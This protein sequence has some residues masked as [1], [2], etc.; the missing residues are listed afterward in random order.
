MANQHQHSDRPDFNS[1]DD[2]DKVLGRAN[3]NPTR[4][5]CPPR[6]VLRALSRRER[7]IEDPAYE[8][9]AKCS[10]CFREFRAMQQGDAAELAATVR[11][12]RIWALAA[13]AVG[14]ALVGTW[15]ILR[16]REPAI[17]PSAQSA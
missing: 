13:A 9:L 3:P 11:S 10:P 14:V 15:S 5:G 16:R 2:I 6:E 4:A 12:H 17:A 1:D 8:H 7:P